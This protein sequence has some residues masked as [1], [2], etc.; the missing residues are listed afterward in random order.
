[1][2]YCNGKAAIVDIG[3]DFEYYLLTGSCQTIWFLRQKPDTY[4]IKHYVQKGKMNKWSMLQH[5]ALDQAY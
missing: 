3:R 4:N 5:D 2:H 1:M